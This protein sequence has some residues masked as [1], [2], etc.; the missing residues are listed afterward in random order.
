MALLHV[1]G[2]I[3]SVYLGIGTII[4]TLFFTLCIIAEIYYYVLSGK[5]S[6][7]TFATDI[8]K[9]IPLSFFFIAFWPIIY[10]NE[11]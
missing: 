9:I 7:S 8:L 3:I 11:E 4:F 5:K 2:L 1:F 10:K 6:F